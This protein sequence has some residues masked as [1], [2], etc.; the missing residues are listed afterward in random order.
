MSLAGHAQDAEGAARQAIT[1][2]PDNA[3]AYNNLGLALMRQGR[4]ADAEAALR[5]ALALRPDFALPHSNILFCLN[6]RPDVTAEAVF[7]EYQRWDRQHAQSLRPNDACY[8]LDRSPARKLRVGYVSPDFRQHAVALFAEPL[9]ANHD[10]SAVEVH[11]YAEVAAPDAVT[12]R[13]HALADHWHHTVGM[14]DAAL[15]EQIRAD[16]IDILVDMAG[17]TAGNRLLVFARKPAPIQVAYLLGHGYSSGLSAMDGFLADVQLAPPDADHLFSER[18]I[19]LSRIPLCT[20]L[21]RKCR[22]SVLCRRAPTAMPRSAI[23][24]GPF[25]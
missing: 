13:F 11:C 20:N 3:D 16:R 8:D 23:S 24:A 4:L 14:S 21:R 19:R 15:A 5:Q 10:R 7:A 1:C 12:E 2:A 25:A 9:L 17:H 22:K 6:Y 18:V